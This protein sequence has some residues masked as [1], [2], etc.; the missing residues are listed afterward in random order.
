M[1]VK[2]RDVHLRHPGN[3]TWCGEMITTEM[4]VS[5]NLDNVTCKKCRANRDAASRGELS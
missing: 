5:V 1:A 2:D 3:E 4:Q